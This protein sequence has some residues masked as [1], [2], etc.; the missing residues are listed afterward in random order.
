MRTLRVNKTKV[1]LKG[2]FINNAFALESEKELKMMKGSSFETTSAFFTWLLTLT[3]KMP[4]ISGFLDC[5]G[6]SHFLT[7]CCQF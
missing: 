4:H 2:A 6:F 3:R 1:T 5:F 7:Y